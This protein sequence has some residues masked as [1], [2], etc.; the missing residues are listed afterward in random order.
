MEG[1]GCSLNRADSAFLRGFLREKKFKISELKDADFILLNACGVKEQTETKMLKRAK[2][3]LALKRKA[4][5]L[6]VYGCLAKICPEKI[7]QISGEILLAKNP[8][9]LSGFFDF[10]AGDELYGYEPI[11]ESKTIGIIPIATGCLGKCTYCCVRNA[12]GKLKSMKPER[13]NEIFRKILTGKNEIW[14]TAQDLGA[15]GKDIGSSLPELL[16]LLLKNKGDYRIRLGMMNPKFLAEFYPQFKKQ[17]RD[18]RIFKFLHI[19]VLAGSDKILKSMGRDYSAADF[20]RLVRKI[21]KDFP[22]AT[23]ST[24]II[25]GFPGETEND[26]KKTLELVKKTRPDIIN[27]SR[28]GARPNTPAEKMRGQLHGRI[29]KERSRALSALHLEI[30][31]EINKKF[32]GKKMKILIDERGP[33]GKLIGRTDNY[34]AVVVERGKLGRFANVKITS[35]EATYLKGNCPK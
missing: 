15:Y 13:V 18:E 30:S 8:A 23:I 25:V 26:F 28:F 6:C 35:A 7:M 17:F 12:R 10:A 32:I 3:L 11:E 9:E 34:K 19:P 1:Y 21:K 22:N 29:K 2:E 14:L 24:D 33:K 16:E 20:F 4:A 31:R 5:K 27:I